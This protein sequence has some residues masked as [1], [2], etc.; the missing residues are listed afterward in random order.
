MRLTGGTRAVQ[1]GGALAAVVLALVVNVVAARHYRRWD[2]TSGRRYT[3]TEPT[4]TTL[5][6]LTEPVDVWLISGDAEP[7]TASLRQLLV[8]YQAE[9]ALVH[10]HPIDPDRDPLALE[11]VRRR[12]KVET[13]QTEEGRVVAD[14]VLAVARGDRHWLV[15]PSD[16]VSVASEDDPRV[17]PREEAA[18]TGAIREVLGGTKAKLCF[19]RGHDE[20]L[21]AD[22]G[23]AGLALLGELL[24]KSNFDVAQ[25]DTTA[26]GEHEPFAGCDVAILAAPRTAFAP[27]ESERLR[28]YLLGGGNALVAISPLEDP[29]AGSK[30]G[31]VASGLDAALAPFGIGLVDALVVE[32]DKERTMPGSRG[33]TFAVLPRPHAV[34]ASLLP[35]ETRDAPRI[36]L[37]FVRPLRHEAS[38][39]VAAADLLVTGDDAYAVSSIA[40]AADWA[41]QPPEEGVLHGAQVVAMA[42][43]RA[44]LS[45]SAAHGPRV[46][47]VG[48]GSVFA[49][50]NWQEPAPLHG[51][52]FFV[53][54]SISWLAARPSIV[55]VPARPKV[56]AGLRLSDASVSDVR[57][58][59][60][61]YMPAAIALLG[62]AIGL[63]RRATEG[64][65]RDPATRPKTGRRR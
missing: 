20:P 39:P 8:A 4:L 30:T 60:L 6:G 47:V 11:D 18:L 25:V 17:E 55:D 61:F 31:M 41:G 28:T 29:V 19:T 59:V 15:T 14:A 65:P 9:S 32:K 24:E 64:T 38:A 13:G 10:V 5:R 63:R 40:G 49:P 62:L 46:V 23:P 33:A 51:A 58:Y 1:L 21:L 54:S 7:S 2:W 27:A 45:P 35:A 48:T 44:K 52:A 12:F 36:I 56:T 16:L 50:S 3:L 34:T 53:E 57:T 43:E 37:G 22:T 26:P 42:A